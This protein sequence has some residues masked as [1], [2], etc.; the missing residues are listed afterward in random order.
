MLDQ[1]SDKNV[2]RGISNSGDSTLEAY[3]DANVWLKQSENQ[4]D[5]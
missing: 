2:S 1:I 5:S 4:I 3:Q